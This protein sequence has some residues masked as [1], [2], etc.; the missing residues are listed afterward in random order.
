MLPRSSLKGGDTNLTCP[1][2]Q[3]RYDILEIESVAPGQMSPDTYSP[4][5]VC[6]GWFFPDNA[7]LETLYNLDVDSGFIRAPLSAG[8]GEF[9]NATRTYIGQERLHKMS[10]LFDGYA[11][12]IVY[13][14]DAHREGISRENWLDVEFLGDTYSRVEL[15]QD[16]IVSIDK[17]NPQE[18]SITADIRENACDDL[19]AD[20]GDEISVQYVVSVTLSSVTDAPWID[21]LRECKRAVNQDNLISAIPLLLSALDNALYRQVYTFYRWRGEGSDDAHQKIRDEFANEHGDLYTKHLAKDALN[22][23]TSTSLCSAMG[24]YG[25]IWNEFWGAGGV[26]EARNDIVHP[27]GGDLDEIDRAT[28]VEWFDLTMNL[29]LGSYELLR[30]IRY[31]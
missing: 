15:G 26:R 7:V 24:P 1:H 22:Q 23:I 13:I 9:T 28:V 3:H 16:I 6:T 18:L 10:N 12:H 21:L 27:D 29:I 8:A 11:F 14:Q 31:T 2:C 17:N 4:C 5:S 20:L 25:E 30:D 19:D